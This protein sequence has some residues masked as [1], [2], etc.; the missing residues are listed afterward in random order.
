MVAGI[1]AFLAP[2][3][4]GRGALGPAMSVAHHPGQQQ[5]TLIV[6]ASCRAQTFVAAITPS[7][8]IP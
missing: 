7:L 2:S 4:A 8:D 5:L 1:T 3:E 6:G